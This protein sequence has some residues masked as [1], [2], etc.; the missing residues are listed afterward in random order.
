MFCVEGVAKTLVTLVG[1]CG[2]G[3]VW[4]Q[5]RNRDGGNNRGGGGGVVIC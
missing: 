3:V 2:R 1:R 5:M 4:V